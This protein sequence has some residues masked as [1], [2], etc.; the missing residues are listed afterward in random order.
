MRSFKRL[1]LTFLLLTAGA[2]MSKRVNPVHTAP[3]G[4]INGLAGFFM[5]CERDVQNARGVVN[6]RELVRNLTHLHRMNYGGKKYYLLERESITEMIQAVTEG[7]YSD[8][9]L[10]NGHGLVVYTRE[11][12]QIFGQNVNTSL[13]G[14]PLSRC[15]S[16]VADGVHLEDVSQFPSSSGLYCMFAASRVMDD[17]SAH[18]AFILQIDLERI[19][20]LI[21]EKTVIIDSDGLYRVSRKKDEILSSYPRIHMLKGSWLNSEGAVRFTLEG[22]V[23]T[24]YPFHFKNLD[25]TLIDEP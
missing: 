17:E 14:S 7:V 19:C 21:D 23:Y 1:V 22:G 5:M 3:T 8:F 25:W 12:D 13:K 11:N 10:V 18:G 24:C 9:I 6:N 2:C 4:E 20:G 15:F 16:S